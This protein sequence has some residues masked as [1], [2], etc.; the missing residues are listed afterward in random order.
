[1]VIFILQSSKI[2]QTKYVKLNMIKSTEKSTEI[3]ITV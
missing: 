1:M 3:E 2:V